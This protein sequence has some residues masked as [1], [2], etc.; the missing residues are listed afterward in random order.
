MKSTFL[1]VLLVGWVLGGTLQ[2]QDARATVTL[3][4]D[5]S[6]DV[7][8]LYLREAGTT[9][10]GPDQLTDTEMETGGSLKLK[11]LPCHTY[12]IKLVDD[13]GKTCTLTQA[14]LCTSAGSWRITNKLLDGCKSD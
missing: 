9:A 7:K 11:D 8:H 6:W 13:G 2:A 1:F 4:N 5:S 14:T 3:I 12:D 10:W